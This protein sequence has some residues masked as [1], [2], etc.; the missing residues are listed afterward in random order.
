MNEPLKQFTE[1][2]AADL[3]GKLASQQTAEFIKQT[4]T[5]GDDRTFEVVFSTSDEDRQGDALDQSKWDLK[6]YEM[7][8][9]VLWAHNYSGF[10]IGIIDDIKIQGNEA[11]ATGKFAPQG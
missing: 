2:L 3:K 8:P 11:V 7:N 9:V 1:Q 6:Y 10:P 5:S 4:K